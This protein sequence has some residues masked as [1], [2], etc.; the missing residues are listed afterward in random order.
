MK[1]KTKHHYT[2]DALDGILARARNNG[3]ATTG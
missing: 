1:R 3:V 2:L